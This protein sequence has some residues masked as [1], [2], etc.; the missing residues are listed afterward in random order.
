M[1]SM[2]KLKRSS[3]PGSVPLPANMDTGELWVNLA[4]KKLFL[5]DSVGQLVTFD[6]DTS[7]TAY[8]NY[9]T[10]ADGS[11]S[12][13]EADTLDGVHGS[14]F[15]LATHSHPAYLMSA[16]D[17]VDGTLAVDVNSASAAMVVKQ[18]GAGDVLRAESYEGDT[19]PT[20]VTADGTV[21]AST[22]T[23]YNPAASRGNVGLAP[24]SAQ[25]ITQTADTE[26]TQE[27]A[28][29][30]IASGLLKNTTT[31]GVITAA[32]VGTDF[33]RPGIIIPV[34][35][36]GTGSGTQAG[37][38]T[39]LGLG[40]IAT[41][42]ASSVSITGG[43]ISGITDLPIADGGTGASSASAAFENIK[44]AATETYTGVV[45]LATAAE[46]STGTDTTR[47]ITPA[48]LTKFNDDRI[49]ARIDVKSLTGVTNA[50]F[51]SVPR[52]DRFMIIS[53]NFG[54][55]ANNVGCKLAISSDNGSTW[56]QEVDVF[57]NLNSGETSE[58][59]IHIYL[60]GGNHSSCCFFCEE[61]MTQQGQWCWGGWMDLTGAVN[62]IR[63]RA[64]SGTMDEGTFELFGLGKV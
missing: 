46:A 21:M 22:I 40:S 12:G 37:A 35:D 18:T 61:S 44:Q 16:G 48:G 33:Y 6:L 64:P 24:S 50:T 62:A 4:D 9:I 3:N 49:L 30:A 17:T 25:F 27:Q 47:A 1:P 20:R 19:S 41:Q 14:S 8:L 26:L 57:G 45:E 52:C 43:S 36:G 23:A 28:T 53:Q 63:I 13:I 59:R 11:G 29:G 54:M 58:G 34:V 56:S 51:T 15:S 5:K 55:S 60:T 38:R 10:Q 2:V 7:A 31:T 42:A 39:N 32:S